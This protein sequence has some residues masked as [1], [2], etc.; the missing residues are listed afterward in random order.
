MNT[1]VAENKATGTQLAIRA[2]FAFIL[3]IFLVTGWFLANWYSA[4]KEGNIDE[5]A[6][7]AEYKNGRN[8]LGQFTAKMTE[9]AQVRTMSIDDQERIIKAVFGKDGRAGNQAAWQWV[10]EQNP[11]ADIS[12]SKQM[13]QIIEGSRNKFENHQTG[14]LARCQSFETKLGSPLDGFFLSFAGYPDKRVEKDYTLA[15]MCTPLESSYSANAFETGID[16]GFQIPK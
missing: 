11:N 13:A 6:I 15:K 5:M 16:N 4:A 10:K 7:K 1:A 9:L 14:I 2:M 12:V 3:L 8:I